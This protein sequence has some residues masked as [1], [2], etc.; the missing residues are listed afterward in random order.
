M[1]PTTQPEFYFLIPTL[2]SSSPH[3]RITNWWEWISVAL[4]SRGSLPPLPVLVALF[5]S[6]TRIGCGSLFGLLICEW[7]RHI[8]PAAPPP[9]YVR[10]SRSSIFFLNISIGLART[11][12][13]PC[14]VVQCLFHLGWLYLRNILG[15]VEA[16]SRGCIPSEIVRSL[17]NSETRTVLSMVLSSIS[18][19]LKIYQLSCSDV[20]VV[21]V[22]S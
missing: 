18:V 3:G 13:L 2:V 5:L 10:D 17:A 16:R 1:G 21:Y 14:T 7:R 12:I 22:C 4:A 11:P 8:A 9:P 20:R 6:P 15:R 19:N